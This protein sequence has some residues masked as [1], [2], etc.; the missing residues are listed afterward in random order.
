MSKTTSMIL[1]AALL[2]AGSLRAAPAAAEESAEIACARARLQ[3]EKKIKEAEGERAHGAEST[4]GFEEYEAGGAMYLQIWERFG[5]AACEA[6]APGCERMEEVLYNAARAYQGARNIDRSIA[7]RMVLVDPRYHLDATELARKAVYEIGGC[8]QATAFYD[9][10]ATW[11]ERYAAM[12]PAAE[13]SPEALSDATVIRLS[14]GQDDKAIK[15]ADL[16][17]KLY[18]SKKP[19]QT[20]T[21]AFAIGAHYVDRANWAQAR[22]RFTGAMGQIDKNAPIDV[23]IQ[24]HAQLGRTAVAL[25]D[26]PLAAAEYGKVRSLFQD[27]ASVV[28]RL[29]EGYDGSADRKVAKVLTAE[30]EAI[31]FFAEEKRR[32]ADAIELPIYKGTGRREDVMAYTTGPLAAWWKERRTAI[33]EAEK[34]YIAVLAL[35]PMSPP[36]WVVASA[37]RTARLHG[38]LAAQLLAAPIPKSWKAQ[39]P[40]P[41]GPTWEQIRAEFRGGLAEASEPELGRAKGAYRMCV[42]LSVQYQY[43]DQH[44]RACAAWLSSH[45]P[46][47]FPRIDEIVDRPNHRYF[48][49]DTSFPAR[50]VRVDP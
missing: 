41:W 38:R 19:A 46:A 24:A 39:G 37:A 48:G 17:N 36:K 47:E 13:K 22:K 20:A 25:H 8:Y 28:R 3:A 43:L 18:G 4:S 12:N 7:V 16:F 15:N 34:A 50:G 49:V 6:R 11:Y 27:P 35:Q 42:K 30:G 21:I 14:L 2:A 40:S 29:T 10:A 5:K 45:S 23:Q 32:A 9:E 1:G 26:D 31:F 33:D 44:S